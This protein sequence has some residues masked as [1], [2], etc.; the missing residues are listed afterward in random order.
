MFL[1]AHF[2]SLS[3]TEMFKSEEVAMEDCG[4]SGPG[5]IKLAELV[6]VLPL[7]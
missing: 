5:C 7:S 4:K 3:V 2:I 1:V 6:A